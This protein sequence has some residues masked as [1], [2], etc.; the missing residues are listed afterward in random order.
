MAAHRIFGAKG[1]GDNSVKR[2]H[3]RQSNVTIGKTS[4]LPLPG[5]VR[6]CRITR[7]KWLFF[8]SVKSAAK[9]CPKGLIPGR[10]QSKNGRMSRHNQ[11]MRRQYRGRQA[12][13]V[14]QDKARANLPLRKQCTTLM[15]VGFSQFFRPA[16]RHHVSGNRVSRNKEVNRL[17][18]IDGRYEC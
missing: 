9:Q 1:T 14:L 18:Q 4:C 8:R 13:E 5:A 16:Y 10:Y 15:T 17:P 7:L 12:H 6:S 11:N 2:R 3:L